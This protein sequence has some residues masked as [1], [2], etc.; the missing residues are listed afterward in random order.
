MILNIKFTHH[1]TY[2]TISLYQKQKLIQPEAKIS[3]YQKWLCSPHKNILNGTCRRTPGYFVSTQFV[4]IP[5]ENVIG[6]L[7]ISNFFFVFLLL[8]TQWQC[9]RKRKSV[10]IFICLFIVVLT[11]ISFYWKIKKKSSS[12]GRFCHAIWLWI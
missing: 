9:G 2:F 6:K 11:K 4:K 5:E 3:I 12:I 7:R 8:Q 10:F 1:N